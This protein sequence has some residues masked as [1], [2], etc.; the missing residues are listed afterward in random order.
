MAETRIKSTDMP[1]PDAIVEYP[2]GRTDMA[3]FF[4]GMPEDTD[5]K[6]VAAANG[7]DSYYLLLEEDNGDGAKK[8]QDEYEN[9]GTDSFEIARRWN[10]VTPDGWTLCEKYDTEDGMVAMFVKPKAQKAQEAQK[11]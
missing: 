10:P 4:Y 8:L 3:M 6:M 2:D 11:E 7:F 9:S 5:S 1:P